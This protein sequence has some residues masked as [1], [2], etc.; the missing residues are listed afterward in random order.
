M[1]APNTIYA[2]KNRSSSMVGYVVPEMNI[3]REFQPGETKKIAFKELEAL[4]YQPG[5]LELIQDYLQTTAEELTKELNVTTEP[6]Y[7]MSED[8]IRDLLVSGSLDAF[9]DC[10]D[11]APEG[12]IE[13]VKDFAVR[14][15]LNDVR[16]R[17]ALREKTGFDVSKALIN[18]AADETEEETQT[19]PERR[20]KPANTKPE[21]ARRTVGDYKNRES[22]TEDL[23]RKGR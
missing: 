20:V 5:G 13:L 18:A 17:D 21:G 7:Y 23:T 12:V 16:K 3:R 14:L 9:L 22:K 10:L 6:E 1:I 2:V 4:S 8:Q 15:P 19:V 11:F